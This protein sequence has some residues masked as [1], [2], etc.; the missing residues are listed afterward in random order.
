MEQEI[1]KLNLNSL[2]EIADLSQ[3]FIGKEVCV[4]GF[5]STLRSTRS[6]SFLILRNALDTIQAIIVKTKN[7]N[8]D[9]FS[10]KKLAVECYVEI[11]GVVK[12]AKPLVFSCTKQNIEI[13]LT[14]LKIL[15]EVVEALPFN[16]KD[17]MAT[18]QE[19]KENASICNVAYN[20]KLDNRFLDLRLPQ[21]QS[22]VRIMDGVMFFFRDFLR[23]NK[24]IEIKTTKIIQS[25]SEGGSNMFS[26]NYFDKKA[27]LAQSPQLYKQMAIIGGLKR[28]FEIGHVYRAEQSN[29]NRYLSEFVGLDIEMELEGT[30]IDTVKFIHKIFVFIFDSIK[31]EYS[32]E[33]EIIR[34]YKSF[35]DIKYEKEP[36]IIT[37]KEGVDILRSSGHEISYNEDFNREQEKELGRVIKEKHGLDFFVITG[38]PAS[39]RAFYTYVDEDGSTR[40]YDFILRGEEILSG[41]QRITDYEKLKEAVLKKG[42]SLESLNNYLEPFKFGPPPHIGCGIGFERLLKSYFGFEDIRYFSLFPRDPNRLYP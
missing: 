33:L 15:G 14:S 11:R 8:E 22:I 26:V 27:Y 31:S 25:G 6:V 13:E 20:L 9:D 24:F 42:I 40:S 36:L 4:R 37:H 17:A 19:R 38:Y 32:N 21:T 34:K 5:V 39:E 29:I 7:F 18:E 10:L 16:P 30:Y 41:A 23:K 35:E 1:E 28:V 12:E 3:D 2:L